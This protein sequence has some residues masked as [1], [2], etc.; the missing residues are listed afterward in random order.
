MRDF[1]ET[2]IGSEEM[3][4]M[5]DLAAMTTQHDMRPV[6]VVRITFFQNLK[7]NFVATFPVL[8]G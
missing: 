3:L 1:V 7:R 6:G 2:D 5:N 8:H 4:E